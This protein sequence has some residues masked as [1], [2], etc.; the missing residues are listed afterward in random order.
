MMISFQGQFGGCRLDEHPT[1]QWSTGKDWA[2][3]EWTTL[4][5]PS[6]HPIWLI[7][8]ALPFTFFLS[9]IKIFIV[10]VISPLGLKFATILQAIS[11]L[12]YFKSQVSFSLSLFPSLGSL[13]W[14]GSVAVKVFVQVLVAQR[15]TQAWVSGF[16]S[17]LWVCVSIDWPLKVFTTSTFLGLL[18]F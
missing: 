11:L 9:S 10:Y 6:K 18:L 15:L 2:V 4:S 8:F 1:L 5:T 17:Q 7:T 3:A 16:L 14:D 13:S 12:L